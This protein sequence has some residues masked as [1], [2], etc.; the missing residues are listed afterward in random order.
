M[1][2]RRHQNWSR[3]K[4]S[5]NRHNVL[6]AKLTFGSFFGIRI[7]PLQTD[8]A[9]QRPP[10][11]EELWV[12]F[13]FVIATS[14]DQMFFGE[15]AWVGYNGEHLLNFNRYRPCWKFVGNFRAPCKVATLWETKC[16]V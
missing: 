4:L 3:W 13:E 5:T 8:R 11:N 15:R 9:G 1:R 7:L 2:H 12:T 14:G 16:I 6:L 10:E